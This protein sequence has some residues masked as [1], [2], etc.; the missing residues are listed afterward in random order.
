MSSST[1][2]FGLHDITPYMLINGIEELIPF[3][4]QV[5]GAEL[6][7]EIKYRDD[8]TLMHAEVAIGDSVVMMGTPPSGFEHMPCQLYVYVK[9]CDQ[10]YEKALELI[11]Q[12]TGN[13]K[14]LD[15]GCGSGT[16]LSMARNYGWELHGIEISEALARLCRKNNPD[17]NIRTA[18]FED[19]NLENGQFSL[20]TLWDVIEH[21]I[22]PVDV[23]SRIK[24]LL[25]DGGV[26]LFCTPDES[27]SLAR[28][29]KALYRTRLMQYPA[30]ALHPPNHT[31]FFSRIG[32][33]KML[34]Q[35]GFTVEHH[36]SQAAFFEHSEMATGVQ[37]W[38]ISTIEWMSKPFDKQYEMV[39]VAKKG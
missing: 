36:Y 24:D 11:G 18:R 33:H 30:L 35:V 25:V 31:Y 17:A 10:V 9:N 1:N 7:G 6:R 16:F 19:V 39:M 29:G 2:P 37:K 38:G 4:Q 15:I 14:L 26:A 3:L 5:F 27:S 20:I 13:A 21:V 12:Q 22:D 23:I 32:F 34:E 8:G 28:L